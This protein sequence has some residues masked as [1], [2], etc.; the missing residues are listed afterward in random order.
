MSYSVVAGGGCPTYLVK[1]QTE[2]AT[3]RHPVHASTSLVQGAHTDIFSLHTGCS[4]AL[5]GMYACVVLFCARFL[6]TFPPEHSHHF[7]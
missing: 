5:P 4:V 6:V 2:Q 3:G 7:T 1:F